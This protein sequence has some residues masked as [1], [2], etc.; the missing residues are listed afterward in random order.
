[1]KK[2][3][4]IL[5]VFFALTGCEEKKEDQPNDQIPI[6]STANYRGIYREHGSYI[7]SVNDSLRM[8]SYDRSEINNFVVTTK[9]SIHSLMRIDRNGDSST[10]KSD[11]SLNQNN[12]YGDTSG[13]GSSHYHLYIK[14]EDDTLYLDEARASGM[15]NVSNWK[16]RAKRID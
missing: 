3:A 15:P 9:G 16:V 10:M 12:E 6:E 4:F 13:G 1:M 7:T 5:I 2:L 14:L 11:F 8:V